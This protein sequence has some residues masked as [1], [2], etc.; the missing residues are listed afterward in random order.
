MRLLYHEANDLMC[1]DLRCSVAVC[2]IC[3]VWAGSHCMSGQLLSSIHTQF[4]TVTLGLH[5]E[6]C[7]YNIVNHAFLLLVL[8]KINFSN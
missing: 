3:G 1:V 5:I 8:D 4:P 7:E 2:D 6:P